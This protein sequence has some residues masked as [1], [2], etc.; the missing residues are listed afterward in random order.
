MF[1]LE[2]PAVV[3]RGSFRDGI[4]PAKTS[5][6]KRK[7]IR[8]YNPVIVLLLCLLTSAPSQQP[9]PSPQQRKP[10]DADVVRVTTNLVQIDALVT[11]KNGRQIT[12]L[13]PEEFE[14][15]QDGRVQKI[16]NLAYI[17]TASTTAEAPTTKSGTVGK[18][19]VAPVPP[20]SLRP[21]QVRRT[22]ALIV[23]D[24]GLSF[25]ST[26]FV[27]RTLTKYINEQMQP[28]DL[29][30]I[31]R[32]SAGAGALQQFT[33]D[34]RQLLAAVDQVRWY[35]L[36]RGTI[37]AFSPIQPNAVAQAANTLGGS[38]GGDRA[39]AD[40]GRLNETAESQQEDLGQ[41]RE[42]AFAVGTLGAVNYVVR[43]L[44]KLP[45]RKSVVLLSDGFKLFTGIKQGFRQQT[46]SNQPKIN[47]RD[48]PGLTPNSRI[49]E[50]LRKLTDAANRASVVVY[51]MDTRGLQTLT[52]TADDN[53][54]DKSPDR[55][56][57]QLLD[58][59]QEF[60]D[61][62]AGLAY[63]A[64]LTGGLAIQN[65]N[66]LNKG[67]QRV[68]DDQAGYY[69]IGYRPD[70]ST[71]DPKTGRP[72][73]HKIAVKV[74]RPGVRVRSRSGFFGVA[75]A[76]ARERSTSSVQLADLLA[77]PFG[78]EDVHLRLT[79]FF[80]DDDR[81]GALVSSVLY[82]DGHD[83]TFKE[84]PDG[85]HEAEI[86]V[87][88]YTFGA[89]GEVVDSLSRT[90][91]IR[92]RGEVYE[93]IL[94]DGLLYTINVPIKKPGAYQLRIALRDSGSKRVGTASQFV[95]VPDLSKERLALS[96]IFISG[97]DPRKAKQPVDPNSR[98]QGTDDVLD[99]QASPA[100]RRFR[101]GME[102][103]YAYYIYNAN[104][105]VVRRPQLTTQMQ[106]FHDGKLAYEGKVTPYDV[107]SESDL[108]RLRSGGNLKLSPKAAS[109]EYVLQ[110]IVTDKLAK[111]KQKTATQWIDFEIVN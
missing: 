2:N 92:A 91:K 80:G 83:L 82:I 11:D 56:E 57:E 12:D 58:R 45:G 74:D 95:E 93:S 52:L 28:G 89:Y 59:R 19:N 96:G 17:S 43:G 26:A 7:M 76:E 66:D 69:L 37:A 36:G 86:E 79:S 46:D 98:S 8:R 54:S 4:A 22:M 110:I 97:I 24:L 109:G 44:E 10:E 85:W 32:T 41:L 87:L 25:V 20:V 14:V 99:T 53:V 73:F 103:H 68:L 75:D 65:E 104:L 38:S 9:K 106:L 94:R 48:T 77:S 27:R 29:V 72:N 64:R 15:V 18:G 34:K 13:Q 39:A 105:D 55:I 108:K 102:M 23:D 88:A 30:A 31:I 21:E 67:L 111:E 63:L 84:E 5:S 51:T 47:E 49:L 3:Y 60:I 107:G 6:R 35:P 50:A 42:E 81:V 62:Q 101:G 70:E 1:N 71:F 33:G 61:T 90:H 40:A 100:L 16:T 78:A